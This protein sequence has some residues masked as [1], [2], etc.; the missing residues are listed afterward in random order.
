[1]TSKTDSSAAQPSLSS[2]HYAHLLDD[3]A[4][5]ESVRRVMPYTLL[6]ESDLLDLGRQVCGVLTLG[7]PGEFVECGVW[8][9]GASFLIADLLRRLDVRNRRAWLFDSFEGLP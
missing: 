1:M 5:M 8:R 9:G 6:A 7:V 3:D 4:L 2:L